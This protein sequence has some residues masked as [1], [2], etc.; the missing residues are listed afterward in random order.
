MQ[1]HSISASCPA[2][3]PAES[4]AT[5]TALGCLCI[6]VG[7]VG[8]LELF[9]VLTR[10]QWIPI[11]FSRK[12]AHIGSGS[13]MT[14]ALVLFPRQY[15]PRPGGNRRTT[16]PAAPPPAALFCLRQIVLQA[17]LSLGC[18][19]LAGHTGLVSDTGPRAWRSPSSWSPSCSSLPRSRTCP[20]T[21]SPRCRR[22]C[23]GGS[24]RWCTRCA[25][26]ASAA[27][28]CAARSSTRTPAL[29]LALPS[30]QPQAEYQP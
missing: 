7:I 22:C 28:S 6:L 11:V 26:L 27:S 2:F 29:T 30:P 9:A 8:Q 12:M 16:R 1:Q 5:Q 21:A 18:A 25:A 20:T 24:S 3:E 4:P 19:A 10:R 14:S 23:A 13:L 17:A 15:W